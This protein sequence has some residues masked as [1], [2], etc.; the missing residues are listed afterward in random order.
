MRLSLHPLRPH[1][2]SHPLAPS[3][4]LLCPTLVPSLTHP[5]SC[6]LVYTPSHP[7]APSRTL[8]HPLAPHLSCHLSP[9]VSHLPPLSPTASLTCRLSHLPSLTHRCRSSL[10]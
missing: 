7:L 10:L 3:C 4:I 8:S 2:L 6:T 1:V 9:A 5:F